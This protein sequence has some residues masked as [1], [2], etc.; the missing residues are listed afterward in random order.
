MDYN[1]AAVFVQVVKAGSFTAAAAKL[2][3]PKSSLSRTVSRLEEELGVRLLHRTTRKLALTEVGHAYYDSVA[4]TF[5]VLDEANALAR[6]HEAEARG[7][8]RMSAPP[9][10]TNLPALVAEFSAR[11]PGI[12]VELSLTARYVDLLTENIDLAVRAGRLED[13]SLIARRIGPA[14]LVLAAAPAYLRKRGRPKR[15]ADLA[16]HDW[17]LYRAASG[18]AQLQL[19]GPD[20]DEMI[21]VTGAIVADDMGFC[22][23]AVEAGAGLGRLPVAA[24]VDAVAAGRLVHVMPEW[25]HDGGS[26]YIVLPSAHFVPRRVALLRDFLVDRLSKQQAELE[27]VCSG[28]AAAGG[29]VPRKSARSG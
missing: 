6:E 1:R 20:G 3:L 23:A 22:R 21:E 18:R 15:V 26:L 19:S 8:V 2:G 12:R 11:H 9:D 13:S 25:H 10:P 7:L 17:V 28:R 29:P 14:T 24:I 16:A 5:D 4:A 27:R